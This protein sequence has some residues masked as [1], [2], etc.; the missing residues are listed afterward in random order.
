MAGGQMT[1]VG[2]TRFNG[3]LPTAEHPVSWPSVRTGPATL[4]VGQAT[5][6][7]GRR[8]SVIGWA[9]L[10]LASASPIWDI[11]R[12]SPSDFLSNR[13]GFLGG[14]RGLAEPCSMQIWPAI[15]IRGGRCVRLVQGDYEKET[16]YGSNPADMAVRFQ[17]DGAAGLHIVDLDGARDGNN[18][19]EVPIAGILNEVSIPCQLGGGIRSEEVIRKYLDMGIERLLIGTMALTD[20]TWFGQMCEKYPDRLLVAIDARDGC[21]L[22]DGWQKTSTTRAVDLATGLAENRI[23]GIVYTDI[24][25]DGMLS[26]PNIDAM[27]EMVE[28]VNI[29]VI[30]SGGVT[31]VDDISALASV[32][33]EGCVIGRALY[34]GHLTL[35]DA[36]TASRK[37]IPS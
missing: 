18:P 37:E 9:V 8:Q 10:L 29:P 15:D 34:E 14:I 5:Q 22:T 13:S 23:A 7:P 12:F 30:A 31:T 27:K 28:A 24:A 1:G 20:S 6:G 17:A 16:V 26:G 32:G 21:A 33:V 11:T 3:S 36:L 35:Q 4:P 2:W 19:N 25:K